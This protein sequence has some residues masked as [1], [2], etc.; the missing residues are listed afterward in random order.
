MA[1]RIG[2]RLQLMRDQLQ[3]EEQRERQQAAARQYMHQHQMPVPPTPAI[4]TPAQFQQP[5]QVPV[6]V[7]R[8]QTHLEN[9]TDYHIRQSQR[10]QLKQYLSTTYGNKQAVHAVTGVQPSPPPLP[11]L[12]PAPG[13]APSPR[14]RTD[15]L[16][17]SGGNSAPN[18]PM[19]LLNISCSQEQ[20]MDEVIDD[21]ISLQS[22][23]DD[24]SAYIDPV[25]QMPNTLPLSS[26]HVDMYTAP[27]MSGPTIAMTSNSCP[28]NL[29]IKKEMSDVE[30]RAL[31]K[32]RQKKDNHNLIERRRRFNINDRIKE[33]G[34]MIPK[35]ND[36]DVR[37]NKGTILKASVDYIKRMQRDVERTREVENNFKK[38]EMANRQL[39]LRIQE[40]EMQARV[41][42]LPCTSPSGLNNTE[43]MGSLM[44][45]DQNLEDPAQGQRQLTPHAPHAPHAPL[46][47]H[48]PHTPQAPHS[49]HTPHTPHTPLTPH[50]PHTTHTPHTHPQQQ[51]VQYPA[52]GSSHHFD[53]AQAL[54][55]CEGVAGYP[56]SLSELPELASL[57][58]PGK[59]EDLGFL[60]MEEALS[61]IGGDPLLSAMS[62]DA[63]VDSR[64]SS[65][66]IEDSEVL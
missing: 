38:M 30:A 64:R 26:S 1:S 27:G 4:N 22:S 43:G 57:S 56:D 39:W 21:I 41:H 35:T 15:Q 50:T 31:A 36:L 25:V 28:P 61:P 19:A 16:L 13:P 51:P 12:Q 40:L 5:M 9:P 65:F 23:Y 53:F 66:S 58:G 59:K 55:M 2:L 54:D 10:Q 7:L 49:L 60:L 3:Q 11:P 46:T 62:P 6:E 44:K 52:V 42:G 8:V 34:T 24:V 32:E 45:P 47:P 33:L 20:E 14:M 37:W 63:S 48:T 17:S 18:S 29:A